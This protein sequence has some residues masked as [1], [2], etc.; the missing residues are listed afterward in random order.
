[1]QLC[2]LSGGNYN[3]LLLWLLLLLPDGL[4]GSLE[5]MLSSSYCIGYP[6]VPFIRL[7]VQLFLLNFGWKSRIH[8]TLQVCYRSLR[9]ALLKLYKEWDGCLMYVLLIHCRCR[10]DLLNVTM[11]CWSLSQWDKVGASFGCCKS[12][13]D[14]LT[15][16]LMNLQV[17]DTESCSDWEKLGEKNEFILKG[18]FI[19]CHRDNISLLVCL[20][21]SC[22]YCP[23]KR[24]QSC[25][26]QYKSALMQA[27]KCSTAIPAPSL[28]FTWVLKSFVIPEVTVKSIEM[29]GKR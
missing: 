1:M 26:H 24:W 8:E 10:C 27:F 2:K 29:Y 23:C 20:Q 18:C 21:C 5:N 15:I 16:V 12:V 7:Q 28:A 6:A 22:P 17:S 25:R 9:S 3:I 4:F 14:A 11:G 19:A 13:L